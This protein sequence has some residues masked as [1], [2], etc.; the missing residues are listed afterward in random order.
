MIPPMGGPGPLD[1]R[2]SRSGQMSAASTRAIVIPI[3]TDG[4]DLVALDPLKHPD[5]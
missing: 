1:E 3:V 4:A 5:Q 2:G